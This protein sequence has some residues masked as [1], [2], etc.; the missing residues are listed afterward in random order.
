MCC[1]DF[2]FHRLFLSSSTS[3]S[4]GVSYQAEMIVVVNST[5][6]VC[7][8]ELCSIIIGLFSFFLFFCLSV[9]YV[10]NSKVLISNNST[11]TPPLGREA[12]RRTS[13]D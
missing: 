11:P 5:L 13:M 7:F 6:L 2:F 9:S 3:L 4:L 10:L 12:K 8:K 1:M